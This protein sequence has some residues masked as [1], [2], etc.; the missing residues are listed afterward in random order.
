MRLV[1]VEVVKNCLLWMV[2]PIGF[3]DRL[4]EV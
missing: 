2:E 1:V 3:A 4:D